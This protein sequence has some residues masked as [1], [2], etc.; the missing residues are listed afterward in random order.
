MNLLII[1]FLMLGES[2][3]N[4]HHKRPSSV[5]FGFRWHEIDPI[6]P[7]ILFLNWIRVIKIPVLAPVN[8]GKHIAQDEHDASSSW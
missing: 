3:H 4:N 2:Y 1:D 6:Y 7:V 8:S 5:N